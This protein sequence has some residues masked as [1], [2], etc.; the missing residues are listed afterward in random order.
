M[1]NFYPSISNPEEMS[2]LRGQFIK[3]TIFPLFEGM[4]FIVLVFEITYMFQLPIKQY[5]CPEISLRSNIFL[6]TFKIRNLTTFIHI[7]FNPNIKSIPVLNNL[8]SYLCSNMM[9]VGFPFCSRHKV[10]IFSLI[11]T[12]NH[13]AK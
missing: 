9:K 2:T 13:S 3:S 12:F 6:M 10:E 5:Y 8:F 1:V 11:I 4:R 7:L